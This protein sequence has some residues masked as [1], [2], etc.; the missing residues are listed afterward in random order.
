MTCWRDQAAGR[1]AHRT[2]S[3]VSINPEERVSA[4]RGPVEA[5]LQQAGC[6][7]MLPRTNAPKAKAAFDHAIQVLSE[8]ADEVSGEW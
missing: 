1:Q 8:F 7:P 2:F 3:V 5:G 4:Q 6:V